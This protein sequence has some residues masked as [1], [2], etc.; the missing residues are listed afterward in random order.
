MDAT[1]VLAAAGGVAE[2]AICLS[3]NSSHEPGVSDADLRALSRP[4][5]PP[6]SLIST[7]TQ[8]WLVTPLSLSVERVSQR[9]PAVALR[10]Q[11]ERISGSDAFGLP[12][13][14][15]AEV[16]PSVVELG[17]DVLSV[18]LRPLRSRLQ[19]KVSTKRED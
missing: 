17:G 5:S 13:T 19:R 3:L 2:V 12:R 11:L 9:D 6:V 1:G 7:E 4:A 15:H 8:Y 14:Q 18:R 10:H 16:R